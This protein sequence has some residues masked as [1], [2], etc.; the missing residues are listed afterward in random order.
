MPRSDLLLVV[1]FVFAFACGG[2]EFKTVESQ[3]AS[4]ASGG[5]NG[6]ESG[7]QTGGN[8]G[9]SGGSGGTETG[10]TAGAGGGTGGSTGGTGGSTGGTGGVGTCSTECV[11]DLP[12]GWNGPAEVLT[13]PKVDGPAQCLGSHYSV[14]RLTGYQDIDEGSLGCQCSCAANFDKVTFEFH[15]DEW[16]NESCGTK[17]LHDGVCDSVLDYNCPDPIVRYVVSLPP[18]VCTAEVSTPTLDYTNVTVCESPQPPS[19]QGCG[20]DEFCIAEAVGEQCV[21]GEGENLPCPSPFTGGRTVFGQLD[22]GRA[23]SP[24][25]CEAQE[26]GRV[27]YFAAEDCNGNPSTIGVPKTCTQF[28]NEM[29]SVRFDRNQNSEARCE[30]TSPSTLTGDLSATGPI[31][32]CCM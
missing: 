27:Q 13:R 25:S 28:Y 8:G 3:D 26:V 2:G 20:Q 10:G 30:P 32:V 1:S 11:P 16:C 18:N 12:P 24:C 9:E 17:M 21:W 23:C 31:T 5:G 22:D 4:A 19:R 6:G 29:A 7:G 15:S 14:E